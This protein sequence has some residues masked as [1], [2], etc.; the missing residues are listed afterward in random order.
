MIEEPYTWL[1]RTLSEGRE[2]LIARLDDFPSEAAFERS[3]YEAIGI[4]SVLWV[5]FTTRGRL[6]GYVA[7]NS[8]GEEANWTRERVRRLHL[9]GEILGAALDRQ[10]QAAA[11]EELSGFETLAAELYASLAAIEA[12]DIEVEIRPRMA[13]G[14]HFFNDFDT[15]PVVLADIRKTYDGPLALATDYMVFNLTKDDVRVRMAAIDE[16]TWPQPATQPK[17][18]PDLSQ[19]TG[20]SD[21]IIGG[22]VPFPEVVQG[23]YDEVN[24]EYGTDVQPPGGR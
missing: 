3:M 16:D 10:R 20:F 21:E 24:A 17:L 12:G 13:V 11:I 23:I 8:V 6:A 19:R 2:I 1:S 15:A 14:Y 5:P 7:Y 22:R 4:R 18:P 9:I